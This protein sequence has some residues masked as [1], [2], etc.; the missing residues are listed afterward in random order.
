MPWAAAAAAA[1]AMAMAHDNLNRTATEVQIRADAA[2]RAIEALRPRRLVETEVFRRDDA[3]SSVFRWWVPALGVDGQYAYRELDPGPPPE[4]FDRVA[5]ER[6]ARL[7]HG[8]EVAGLLREEMRDCMIRVAARVSAEIMRSSIETWRAARAPARVAIGPSL[9]TIDHAL[10]QPNDAWRT[11]EF[12]AR[13]EAVRFIPYGGG[14]AGG[15]GDWRGNPGEGGGGTFAIAPDERAR[16]RIED[17]SGL[18]D[19]VYGVHAF[20]PEALTHML[21]GDFDT[22]ARKPRRG[23]PERKALD[24]LVRHLS[25][26]QRQQ[27]DSDGSFPVLVTRGEHAGRKFTIKSHHSFNVY[28]SRGDSYCA[29]PVIECPLYDQLLTQKLML[30]HAPDQFFSVAN[31]HGA[32]PRR[33]RSWNIPSFLGPSFG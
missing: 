20:R 33:P 31:V 19:L 16:V 3:M 30:E 26:V 14:G 27:F 28:G 6:V 17:V 32:I 10:L 15:A 23:S 8:F 29:R 1:T 7:L 5:T 2:E 11:H 24:L 21:Y 25:P 13:P 22:T 4:V 18:V 12:A 9:V